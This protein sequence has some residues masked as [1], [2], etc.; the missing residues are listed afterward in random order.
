MDDGPVTTVEL[1]DTLLRTANFL[2]RSRRRFLWFVAGVVALVMTWTF[3]RGATFT[4]TASF[5]PQGKRAPAAVAGLAAQL[6]LNVAAGE[7]SQSPAFYADLLI[8]DPI[9]AGLADTK[10]SGAVSGSLLDAEGI[11]G[12]SADLR[13]DAAVRFLRKRIGASAN[14]RTGVVNLSIRLRNAA[15]ARAVNS[16]LLELLNA[17][18]LQTRRSQATAEREFTER[19]LAEARSELRELEDRR[20]AF[21]VRNRD[22]RSSPTLQAQSE[23]L[24]R[25]GA[26]RQSVYTT[27]AQAFEQARIDEVRDTPVIT[28][29]QVPSTPV[30]PDSRSAVPMFILAVLAGAVLGL[31][32]SLLSEMMR[33]ASVSATGAYGEFTVLWDGATRGPF[34]RLVRRVLGRRDT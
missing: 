15:W 30:R 4:S 31:G 21:L 3:A 2:L 29:I 1:D 19:R 14:S 23:R 13:R 5:V 34:S 10:Y 7:P 33:G 28:V 8:S 22:L 25:E 6:G 18:N 24:E 32:V 12:A 16:R 27:L 9:L 17:F 26:F 20:E 11:P